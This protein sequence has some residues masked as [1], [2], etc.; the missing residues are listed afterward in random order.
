M[1]EDIQDV[2]EWLAPLDYI[3]FWE[4]IAPYRLGLD[5]REFCDGLIAGGKM[6]QEKLLDTLKAL[7]V[8]ELRIRLGLKVRVTVPPSAQYLMSVH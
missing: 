3:A 2:E 7:T 8:M 4:A 6:T 1:F 5:D